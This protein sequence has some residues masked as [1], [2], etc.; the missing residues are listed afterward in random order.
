LAIYIAG[1]GLLDVVKLHDTEKTK[2]I[3][4]NKMSQ[5]NKYNVFFKKLLY[6][7]ITFATF[8]YMNLFTFVLPARAEVLYSDVPQT[9]TAGD[10]YE[11]K[12]VEVPVVVSGGYDNDGPFPYQQTFKISAYYSPILGQA[13]YVTGSYEGDVRL[14]GDGVK[15]ADGT[16]VYPGMVAAPKTYPFGVKMNIPG[17]GTVAVHD[18]GGAIVHTGERGNSYDRLD[19]WMG[20]GDAGLKRALTWGKRTVKVTVYGVDSSITEKVTLEGYSES[21]KYAV[22]NTLT[23]NDDPDSFQNQEPVNEQAIIQFGSTLTIGSTGSDVAKIQQILKDLGY[24]GGEV[25]SIFDDATQEAVTKFQIAENI[26]SDEFAFGAGFVGPKTIK[27]LAAKIGNIPTANAASFEL[28][29]EG[30]FLADLNPGDGGEQVRKLQEELRNI[31]LLGIEPTGNY[32]EV[33][34]HAVFKLQQIYGL[35]GDTNSLGVGIFGPKT[36]AVLNGI[37]AERERVQKM[38][39]DRKREEL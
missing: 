31:N 4:K 21:E 9:L 26:V 39:A 35:A 27:I 17:V 14:N 24:Y 37:I 5:G 2:Q 10:F 11:A 20:Y 30:A 23:F 12:P 32:G 7:A 34:E 19:V 8:L 38:I 1:F 16:Q 18:R 15:A 28:S 25:N 3:N 36:R 13:K 6:S 22:A 29:N 33:T